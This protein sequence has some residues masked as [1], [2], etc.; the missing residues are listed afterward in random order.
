MVGTGNKI[1]AIEQIIEGYLYTLNKKPQ[2]LGSIEEIESCFFLLD[3]IK[4]I[5]EYG[6]ENNDP[7]LS[8]GAF[9]AFKGI[10]DLNGFVSSSIKDKKDPYR[11]LVDLRN[12]YYRWIKFKI[13]H[14]NNPGDNPLID[15][16][17]K[18]SKREILQLLSWFTKY[19]SAKVIKIYSD[20]INRNYSDFPEIAKGLSRMGDKDVL[21]W[22]INKIEEMKCNDKRKLAIECLAISPLAEADSVIHQIISGNLFHDIDCLVCAF[23]NSANKNKF[24]WIKQIIS[25]PDYSKELRP[26]VELTLRTLIHENEKQSFELL[27]MIGVNEP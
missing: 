4:I 8:W 1:Q 21:N 19:P 23:G 22:S 27:G 5:L 13:W 2:M 17:E 6:E 12:E 18:S 10:G 3:Q 9:L 16:L 24:D 26:S 25:R 7:D 14:K 11:T 15:L 20:R